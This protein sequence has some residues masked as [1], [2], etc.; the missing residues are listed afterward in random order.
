DRQ[1]D[2]GELAAGRRL[3]QG[4]ERETGIRTYEE[5]HVVGAGRTGLTRVD[6][7]PELA[8]AE[9]DPPQLRRDGVRERDR[10]GAS[11]RGERRVQTPDFRFR[12]RD[13]LRRRL[14]GIAS[15]VQGSQLPAGLVAAAEELLVGLRTM[16]S[17]EIG[18]R[19]ELCLELL[20]P[21]RVGLERR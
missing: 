9:A 7:D 15:V 3:G 8:V 4:A 2:P 5:A 16:P 14:D 19:V 20:E 13:G 10:G 18:V 11:G 6:L 1:R 12:Q 21:A 17:T